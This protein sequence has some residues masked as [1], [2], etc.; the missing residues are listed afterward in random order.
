LAEKKKKKKKK[1]NGPKGEKQNGKKKINVPF[2]GK[3][4]RGG[5]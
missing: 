3:R 4:G 5:F 2:C 1:K